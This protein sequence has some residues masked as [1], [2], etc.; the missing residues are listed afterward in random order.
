MFCKDRY[1][2][3][4]CTNTFPVSKSQ[5]QPL[6]PGQPVVLNSGRTLKKNHLEALFNKIKYR[7]IVSTI[8]H[9]K[10]L[11]DEAWT[12]F[13]SL[14]V[15]S[16]SRTIVVNEWMNE[17]PN[18]ISA[19]VLLIKNFQSHAENKWKDLWKKMVSIL[20]LMTVKNYKTL[21]AEQNRI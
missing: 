4:S 14:K 9:W 11:W 16:G 6:T 13:F 17:L 10:Q 7:C 18:N 3:S 20:V 5:G 19:K 15:Q 21:N 1:C 12:A 8:T 2:G